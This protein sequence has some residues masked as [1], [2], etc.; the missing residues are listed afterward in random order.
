LKHGSKNENYKRKIKLVSNLDFINKVARARSKK[1]LLDFGNK[2][3][4]ILV[5]LADQFQGSDLLQ[6][7]IFDN[8]TVKDILTHLYA[9][10]QLFFVW[11]EEGMADK[12]PEI[13]A[14]GYT[15]KTTP[16]LNEKLYQDHK[17]DKWESVLKNLTISHQKCME[18]IKQHSEEELFTKKKYSWTGTTSMGSYFASAT[19]SHYAWANDLLRKKIKDITKN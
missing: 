5:D 10:H 1:E 6:E 3:F 13:P 16:E 19:S 11:Y 2:E 9:W 18:F 17:E 12:K 14:P 8:R 4:G 7:N 15:F